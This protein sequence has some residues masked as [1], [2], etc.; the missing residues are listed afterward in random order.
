MTRAV[1]LNHLGRRHVICAYERD[2]LVVDPGPSS[3]LDAL[4]AGLQ[5]EPRALLLTHVHLDH[6]GACG[7][8]AE[9][10]PGLVIYVHER[11]APHMADPSKL[12][13]SAARLYGADMDRRWGEVRPVP[14][15][16]L[17]ALV[18]GE[19]VE[20]LRVAYTPGHA[21]HHVAFLSDDGEAF[22]GDVGGVRMPGATY[23]V[24]PTPPPD[25]DVQAWLAALDAVEAWDPG[26]LCLTHFGRFEDVGD[27]LERVREALG[28]RATRA[29]DCSAEE[30]ARWSEQQTLDAVDPDTAAALFQA[31]PPD[32]LGMGL[33]RY[34]DKMATA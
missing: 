24:P 23:T 12:I 33:R 15:H 10:F 18:G 29:R 16:R 20:G 13:S 26:A 11:G 14:R 19:T 30:F 5:T 8:L 9:H 32:Q 1:D 7:H 22:V 2:G 21:S 31:A 27:Q 3:C 25:V 4:L 28:E 34:W 6:A 17:R